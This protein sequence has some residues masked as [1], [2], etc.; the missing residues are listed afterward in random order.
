MGWGANKKLS[1]LLFLA[2]VCL[3]T[4][5]WLL[6]KAFLLW[7]GISC[8]LDSFVSADCQQDKTKFQLIGNE[9]VLG[10]IAISLF[11]LQRLLWP[12]YSWHAR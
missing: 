9:L 7:Y 4:Q 8:L 11:L 6:T 12:C 1:E 5:R 3:L 10:I 2:G